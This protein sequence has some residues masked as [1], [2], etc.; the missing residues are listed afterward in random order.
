MEINV[1]EAIKNTNMC[2]LAT[3]TVKGYKLSETDEVVIAELDAKFKEIGRLGY[4]K[5]HEI[6]AFVQRAINEE[7][8]NTPSEILDR[9]FDSDTIGETDAFEGV[10]GPK[11]TLV[12]Y[13][14]AEGGNVA[15]SYLDVT[16]LNPKWHNRQIETEISYKDLERNG[17][18]TVATIV[19]YARQAFTNALFND[20]FSD[21]DAAIAT[22]AEN[23]LTVSGNAVTQAAAD[24]VALYVNDW[25]E[26]DGMIV[27]YTK[28][29]QQISKLNGHSSE[30]MKNELHRLGRLEMFDG[31][32]LVPVSAVRKQ[33]DGTG[34]F[35]DN[36][37]FGVA[38]KIGT[39]SMRGDIKTYQEDN[40]NK[41]KF[42]IKI[43]GFNY[44]YAF[45][46]EAAEK[47]FKV[48]L[49]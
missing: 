33:G 31:V 12:A 49:G 41:E 44:G 39:L 13:E 19:D 22:G 8:Y 32:E 10:M 37:V 30:D 47:V 5:D 18:K 48:V 25:A 2:E 34:M 16:A 21:L 24:A 17:W 27:G 7:V 40:I 35:V 45:N 29:I 42:H 3:K 20:V 38:G 15:R 43:A 28:Y 1:A 23:C 36:R 14:A 46:S 9:M 6:S 4:D 26:G 11:N